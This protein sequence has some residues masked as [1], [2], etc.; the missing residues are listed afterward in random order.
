MVKRVTLA[1]LLAFLTAL[2]GGTGASAH[3]RAASGDFAT[4]ANAICGKAIK[5]EQAA[6]RLY[7]FKD[8]GA[9]LKAAQAKGAKWVAIDN[10]ALAALKKLKPT[11][12]ED[13]FNDWP[14]ALARHKLATDQL[15]QAI[16]ALKV[17]KTQKFVDLFTK[18]S[19]SASAFSLRAWTLKLNTCKKWTP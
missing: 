19:F 3:S 5:D 12:D 1:C 16:A 9:T 18:S 6:G 14:T 2:L 4:K 17:G 11:S 7:T 15:A 13:G 10:A 8:V